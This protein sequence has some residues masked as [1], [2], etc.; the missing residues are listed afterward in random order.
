MEARFDILLSGV[1]EF[2][3]EEGESDEAA[4]FAMKRI[5]EAAVANHM[6]RTRSYCLEPLD[7]VDVS[8]ADVK[9]ET[10]A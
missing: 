4:L 9:Y 5:I 6:A 8:F 1:V 3:R 7:V 2:E 10:P